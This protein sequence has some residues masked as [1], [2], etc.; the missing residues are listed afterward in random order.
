MWGV[1]EL[2]AEHIQRMEE[3][4]GVYE[5][6]YDAANLWFAL[7]ERPVSLR[8]EV[9]PPRPP[10]PGKIAKRDSEYKRWGTANVFSAVKPKAGRHFTRPTPD[11]SGPEWAAALGAL[12]SDD[13]GAHTIP[14]VMDHLNPH[15][16][17][18]LT[19]H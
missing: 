1:A 9:R 19:D 18:S 4:L 15:C 17:K 13:P 16:R 11:R 14:M 10:A 8:A 3:V 12:A 2:D 6:P 5:K 7:D